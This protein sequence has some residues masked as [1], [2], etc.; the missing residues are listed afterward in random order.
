MVLRFSSGTSWVRNNIRSSPP[1]FVCSLQSVVGKF[2]HSCG[3]FGR[4]RC[5]NSSF[6]IC[7]LAVVIN[8]GRLGGQWEGWDLVGQLGG[9]AGEAPISELRE[10]LGYR[11]VKRGSPPKTL[12]DPPRHCGGQNRPAG[13]P[14]FTCTPGVQEGLYDYFGA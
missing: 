13:P 9:F 12:A 6:T 5:V 10:E 1:G 3:S 7:E 4:S 8:W 14:Y 11:F 2:C